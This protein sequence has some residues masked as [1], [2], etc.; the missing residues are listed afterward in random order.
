M[1]N[2]VGDR[3]MLE[4]SLRNLISNAVKFTPSGG[5]IRLHALIQGDWLLLSVTDTG[6]GLSPAQLARLREGRRVPS[7]IGTEGEAGTGLGLTLVRHFAA[8][9]GGRLDLES[10]PGEGTTASLVLPQ[11]PPATQ[12]VAQQ[13]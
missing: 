3:N 1:L 4:T 13:S 12:P 10:N 5:V 9:H 11:L 6:S 2:V 8:L 7:G